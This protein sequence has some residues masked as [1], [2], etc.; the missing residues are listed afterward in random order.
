MDLKK[1][2]ANFR[3]IWLSTKRQRDNEQCD[4]SLSLYRFMSQDLHW[5]R[6]DSV[7]TITCTW[8][9]ADKIWLWD[10]E[11]I[12]F[13]SFSTA[14]SLVSG[15]QNMTFSATVTPHLLRPI[16]CDSDSVYTCFLSGGYKWNKRVID[17]HW[18]SAS[19]TPHL[20][21]PINDSVL[22]FC[23]EAL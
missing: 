2:S 10:D 7:P 1:Q 12:I 8:S 6:T 17:N 19:V 21:L 15:H 13:I 14:L 20:F 4:T 11:T 18:I 3:Q 22:V 5:T 16:I 23:L 9:A